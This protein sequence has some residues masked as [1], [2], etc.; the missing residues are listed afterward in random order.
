M[1]DNGTWDKE[2]AHIKWFA[3][4]HPSGGPLVV[5]ETYSDGNQEDITGEIN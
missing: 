3:L 4:E 1:K 5:I 2:V